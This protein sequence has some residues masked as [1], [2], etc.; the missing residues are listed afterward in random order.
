MSTETEKILGLSPDNRSNK[1]QD[2]K[3]CNPVMFTVALFFNGA[4]ILTF[5]WLFI[6]WQAPSGMSGMF[7]IFGPLLVIAALIAMGFL[8]N[9]IGVIRGEPLSP[10]SGLS[11]AFSI[12][13]GIYV[14]I[15][16][17]EAL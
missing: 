4:S 3:R 12:I 17:F 14:G 5:I 8:L 2:Q 6:G 11:L 13:M 9:L 1:R 15:C 16:F 10:L 7:A